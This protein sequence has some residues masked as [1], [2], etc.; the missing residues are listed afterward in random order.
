MMKAEL[1]DMLTMAL[2][3]LLHASR[4]DWTIYNLERTKLLGDL[5]QHIVIDHNR[6][7]Y[8][9]LREA[10]RLKVEIRGTLGR[11]FINKLPILELLYLI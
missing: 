4:R 3:I 11:G 2:K 9:Q 10:G 1:L 6:A 7:L 8:A 5:L